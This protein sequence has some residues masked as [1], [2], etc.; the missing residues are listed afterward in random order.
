MA[1]AAN[2]AAAVEVAVRAEQVGRFALQIVVE[3][4]QATDGVGRE[5]VVGE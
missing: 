1:L 5:V 4:D 3:S 2:E